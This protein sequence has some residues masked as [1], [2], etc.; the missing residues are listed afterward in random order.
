MPF[1][2]QGFNG[3]QVRDAMRWPLAMP[4]LPPQ[5]SAEYNSP[6]GRAQTTHRKPLCPFR[7]WEG[8]DACRSAPILRAAAFRK[9]G[10]RPSAL[11]TDAAGVRLSGPAPA[12]AAVAGSGVRAARCGSDDRPHG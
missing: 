3:K 6:R 1:T 2:G 11:L 10:Y 8:G 4:A 5:R 9:P 12:C 7:A